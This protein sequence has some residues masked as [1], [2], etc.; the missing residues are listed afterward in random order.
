M[1]IDE[2]LTFLA[3]R[4]DRDKDLVESGALG[5]LI[6]KADPLCCVLWTLDDIRNHLNPEDVPSGHD[7]EDVVGAIAGRVTWQ[8]L[9]DCSDGNSHILDVV[10]D[11]LEELQDER[12]NDKP[13]D[14]DIPGLHVGRE[15]PF[16]FDDSDDDTDGVRYEDREGDE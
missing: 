8:M 11:Y 3:A 1:T 7:Y 5:D 14:D 16:D 10:E 2:A 9:S 12:T 15:Y 6:N 13:K 4:T